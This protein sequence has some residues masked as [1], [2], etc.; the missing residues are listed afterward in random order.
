M[1]ILLQDE[2]K[3][4]LAALRGWRSTPE[5]IQKQYELDSFMSVIRLVNRVAEAA[6][7]INHHPDILINYDK[8]TFTLVTHDAGG[9]TRRDFDLATR[10]ETLAS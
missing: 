3:Q 9:V 10:I 1:K 7:K 6:E 2:I 4:K 5:G 8:V